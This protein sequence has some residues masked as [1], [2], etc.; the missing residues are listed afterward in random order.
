MRSI[1]GDMIGDI[2]LDGGPMS[3]APQFWHVRLSMIFS[4]L[5]INW[6]LGSTADPNDVRF[7]SLADIPTVNWDVCFTSRSDIRRCER[8]VR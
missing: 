5:G 8:Y 4:G 6:G 2:E 3:V 7:G 1:L